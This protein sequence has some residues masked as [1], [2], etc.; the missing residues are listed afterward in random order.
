MFADLHLHTHHSDGI[1][2]PA[3]VIRA[4]SS[5]GLSL[6][7]ISDHDN[8][9]AWD[10]AEPLAR[11]AGITLLP[12]V[13]LSIDWEGIDV[14]V[15]AYAFDPAASELCAKLGRC[16]DTRTRRGEM[17]VDQLRDRGIPVEMKRVREL[18]GDGAM[19]RPH[20][21]RC[22][23]E[24]G[25][26]SSIDQAFEEFLTPGRPGWV[27]KER[28]TL[29]EAVR[30]VRDAGGVTSVAH[31]TLYPDGERL[32]ERLIPLGIDGIEALHPDVPLE[33][34]ERLTALARRHGLLVTGGSDD[35]GFEDRAT[36]GT[37]HLPL[38]E[39]APILERWQRR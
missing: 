30:L 31:P 14:H 25:V 24:Q 29:E 37:I 34:R 7:S 21:A 11:A 13:E 36:I 1:R 23:V 5:H 17:M 33:A 27:P 39:A 3:E 28:M 19:G 10:E 32:V 18:C 12:G 9:A 8:L 15:L 20:I 35:H 6:I 38:E 2:S 4:A 26:V 22:L 16:R